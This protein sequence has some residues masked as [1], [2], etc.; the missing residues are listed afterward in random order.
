MTPCAVPQ[1]ANTGS[2]LPPTLLGFLSDVSHFRCSSLHHDHCQRRTPHR[3]REEH[4]N[5]TSSQLS[6]ST[7]EVQ[8]SLNKIGPRGSTSILPVD[9]LTVAI[10]KPST[11]TPDQMV[12]KA[13]ISCAPTRWETEKP[14]PPKKWVTFSPTVLAVS[15][16]QQRRSPCRTLEFEPPLP[17]SEAMNVGSSMATLEPAPDPEDDWT[18]ALTTAR[19]N[20]K[21]KSVEPRK[22]ILRGMCKRRREIEEEKLRQHSNRFNPIQFNSTLQKLT[23][24]SSPQKFRRDT[25]PDARIFLLASQAE[26]HC[27]D[28]TGRQTPIT[29]V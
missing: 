27:Q 28:K 17:S 7:R 25:K 1:R 19:E 12:V 24:Q 2:P 14:I 3:G 21:R 20:S 5:A 10:I 15:L 18:V 4:F 26:A 22:R 13:R 29:T 23:Y 6:R 8:F 16:G 11:S 9:R